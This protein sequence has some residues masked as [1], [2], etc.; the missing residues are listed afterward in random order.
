MNKQSGISSK[1]LRALLILIISTLF[2][3]PLI[4]REAIASAGNQSE[5]VIAWVFFKDKGDVSD[6]DI[7]KSRKD[8][9]RKRSAKKGH[10][11][12]TNLFDF[13]DMPVR[14]RY[15]DKVVKLGAEKRA[16]TKWLNGISV[17]AR[18]EVIKQIRSLKFVKKVK[19]IESLS[20]DAT[21]PSY[22][23]SEIPL[24]D[25]SRLSISSVQTTLDYGFSDTQLTQ[26]NIPA[27]HDPGGY[28]GKDVTICV[29]DTGFSN[30]HES[31]V[32]TTVLAERDFIND[33][34]ETAN[35][36]GDPTGIYDQEV[37]GTE[38]LSVVGGYK[39]GEVIGSAYGADFL[40]AKTEI[41]ATETH[42][43]ED[44]WLEA[45]EWAYD[46]GAD[47]VSSSLA[48]FDGFSDSPSSYENKLDGE[49]AIVTKAANIAAE[50]GMLVVNAVGNS[51][52][53]APADG[54][55]LIAVGGVTSNG[56]VYGGANTDTDDGR[57]KPDVVAMGAAVYTADPSGSN[58]FKYSNG[59]SFATPI[60]SGLSALLLESHPDWSYSA[61]REAIINTS[62]NADSTSIT[63]GLGYGIPD[64][65]EANK[66]DNLLTITSTAGANG[67][68]Y[69]SGAI[70]VGHNSMH[71]YTIS[72]DDN[73]YV[74]SLFVDG[75]EVTAAET[76][77]YSSVLSDHTIS[78]TFESS[79][80]SIV[81][82]KLKKAKVKRKYKAKLKASGGS[83]KYSW[84]LVKKKLPKGLKLKKNGTITGKPKSKAKGKKYLFTVEAVDK[85][86]GTN[87]A[88]KQ[89]KIKVKK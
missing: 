68:I 83:G 66:Y 58:S 37:H 4:F 23:K 50:K 48:Y 33:D 5:K 8:F 20:D 88:S 69:P 41:N 1:S 63:S 17:E 24:P 77:K 47:I 45:I 65:V 54:K 14:Q 51:G 61:I 80:I 31:I 15:I 6:T 64:A 56:V 36:S 11:G 75:E 70:K 57:V 46:N 9:I 29:I 35:E 60:V 16:V 19:V 76:Y 49:A 85:S 3:C 84:K 27:L 74:S 89:F 52:L 30:D 28:T 34:N 26:V 53:K 73:Y 62:S 55:Y 78:A 18:S 86:N 72:P 59:T 22:R 32:S 67:A 10:F 43:E 82:T 71:S 39:E 40:L 42:I 2:V 87:T 81:T 38:V 12:R 79:N 7:K 25:N 21:N 44:Y 13:R